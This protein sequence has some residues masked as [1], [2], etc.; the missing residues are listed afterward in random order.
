MNHRLYTTLYL[1]QT[2]ETQCFRMVTV[3]PPPPRSFSFTVHYQATHPLVVSG[4]AFWTT[5]QN[6]CIGYENIDNPNIFRPIFSQKRQRMLEQVH[7]HI[8][9]PYEYRARL[10]QRYL[11]CIMSIK[12]VPIVQL[13]A[14]CVE[15]IVRM[16]GL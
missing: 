5:H 6:L 2:L 11:G 4:S 9:N 8:L 3:Q 7:R 14:V 16:L 10:R 13:P 15:H 12:K 1:S